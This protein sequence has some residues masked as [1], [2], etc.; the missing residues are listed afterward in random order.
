MKK[1]VFA[2]TGTDGIDVSETIRLGEDRRAIAEKPAISGA[3]RKGRVALNR[4][5]KSVRGSRG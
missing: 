4:P 2:F 1:A 3:E 5:K